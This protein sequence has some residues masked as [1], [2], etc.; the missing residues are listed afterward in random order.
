LNTVA[1]ACEGLPAP[2]WRPAARRFV[3]RVLDRLG[4]R[5]WELSVLL[6]DNRTIQRLNAEYRKKNAPTDVL[7]FSQGEAAAPAPA[8]E[9]VIAG[10][11]VISL[12]QCA[13][14]A[15][16]FR[17]KMDDELKRLFVHGILH[18]AGNEHR[19][20]A[21]FEPMLQTQEKLLHEMRE[22]RII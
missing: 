10:D 13:E 21:P 20:N 6:C 3:R 5:N 18:L 19:S 15:R 22:V 16:R 4:A 9:R 7:S 8:G 14:N 1:I 11:L 2:P 12:E 17:V